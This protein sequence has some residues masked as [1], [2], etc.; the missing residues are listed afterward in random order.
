MA[1]H[2]NE[3]GSK[4][5]NLKKLLAAHRHHYLDVGCGEDKVPEAIGMDKRLVQGVD[6]VHD[7]EVLPWPFPDGTFDT[8]VASHIMEHVKPWLTFDIVDEVWRV[9]KPDGKFLIATPYGM[10]ELFMQ[11]PSHVHGWT[12]RTP[13]YFDPEH[14]SA[15]YTIYRPLPWKICVC[16]WH[17]DGNMEIV[18]QKRPAMNGAGSHK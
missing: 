8:V 14:P 1:L 17:Q 10:N 9:L 12:E 3:N 18:M 7:L 16:S 4:K 5:F 2:T 6:V 15:L 13:S 11:D